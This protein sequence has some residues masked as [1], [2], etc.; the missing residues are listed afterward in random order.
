[1]SG[2]PPAAPAD[3]WS[4]WALLCTRGMHEARRPFI[5]EHLEAIAACL[6]D[7][8]VFSYLH[9]PVQSASNRCAGPCLQAAT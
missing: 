2:A 4:C 1:M 3:A 9:I 6:N 8:R 5:L 7:P